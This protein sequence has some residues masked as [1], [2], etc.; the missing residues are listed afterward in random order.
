MILKVIQRIVLK[1]IL[2]GGARE[3]EGNF[4]MLLKNERGRVELAE[5]RPGEPMGPVSFQSPFKLS[6]KP[7]K[8]RLLRG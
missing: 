3:I 5:T 7:L 6:K 4:K 2:M 1:V 8:L